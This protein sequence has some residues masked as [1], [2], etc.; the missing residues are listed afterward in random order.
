MV[1]AP[2][3]TA[4]IYCIRKGTNTCTV[5]LLRFLTLAKL[6]ILTGLEVH[7]TES[8]LSCS[9]EESG[10]VKWYK[11]SPSQF[12]L[13]PFTRIDQ[14]GIDMLSRGGGTLVSLNSWDIEGTTKLTF[15]IILN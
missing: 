3:V 8:G 10:A 7:F 12:H 15:P 2:Q 11:G 4:V 13:L 5:L 14:L 6:K 1:L 9:C